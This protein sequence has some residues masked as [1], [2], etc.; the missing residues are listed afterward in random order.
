MTQ[1]ELLFLDSLEVP[2]VIR[3]FS[4]HDDLTALREAERL[5]KTHTIEV[6][7]GARRVARVKKGNVALVTED[8]QSL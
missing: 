2:V 4:A 1:F 5:S 7:D 6:W 8:R 3:A